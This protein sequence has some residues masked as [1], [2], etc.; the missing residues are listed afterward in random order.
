MPL[1]ILE[2]P[3]DT[4]AVEGTGAGFSV[5]A[6][7]KGTLSYQWYKDDIAI[8]GANKNSLEFNAVTLQD[9]GN[10]K[11][12]VKDST[13]EVT[14]S[15]AKLTVDKAL[16][17]TE[18]PVAIELKTGETGKLSVVAEGEGTLSYQWYKDDSAVEGA[19][20][21]ELEFDNI[22]EADAGTYKVRVGDKNGSIDS[23]EVSVT[24]LTLVKLSITAQPKSIEVEKGATASLKVEAVGDGDLSYKWYKDGNEIKNENKAELVLS[25]NDENFVGT[26]KVVVSD[27]NTSITSDEVKV[28]LKKEQE[29]PTGTPEETPTATPEETPG[30]TPE[31][32]PTVTPEETPTGSPE[33]TPTAAPEETTT[34]QPQKTPTAAPEETPASK[35]DDTSTEKPVQNPEEDKTTLKPDEEKVEKPGEKSSQM[36]KATASPNA[37][38]TIV[39]KGAPKTGED[40][41]VIICIV[42]GVLSSII[43]VGAYSYKKRRD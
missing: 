38:N 21:P 1:S 24:V 43:V 29:E 42:A 15:A 11:V 6:A 12:V 26:Y 4:T 8:D 9:A 34:A 10:Y 3:A 16:K 17:I 25:T 20:G 28:T 2:Q 14:S 36:P 31:I 13:G 33:E 7:G 32:T 5:K 19:T 40:S 39:S 27:A 41:T 35:P 37:V 23:Q 30:T 18:E 22:S